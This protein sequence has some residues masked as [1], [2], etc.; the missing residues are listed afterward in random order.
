MLSPEIILITVLSYFAL[1]TLVSYI[2]GK[3]DNNKVFFKANKN[4]NWLIVAFG[5]VGASL[6][7]V[8]FISV[9]GWVEDTQFTYFQVVLYL[10]LNLLLKL[11]FLL[12]FSMYARFLVLNR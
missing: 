10:M 12:K 1:L 11:L 5:M 2:T 3:E 6:S 9:P 8:T 4:S 7:G